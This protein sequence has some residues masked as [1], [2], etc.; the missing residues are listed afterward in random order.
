M[1]RDHRRAAVVAVL[2]RPAG[3]DG[4]GLD[5]LSHQVTGLEVRADLAGDL[6]PRLL[7]HH[8]SGELIYSLRSTAEGGRFG[9]TPTERCSRLVAAARY[10]DLIDLEIRDLTPEAL[11]RIPARQRRISWHGGPLDLPALRARFTELARTPARLYVLA[12]RTT[13]CGQ[14]LIPLQLLRSLGRA[15]V[16]AFGT[17]PSGT[18]SRVLAAWLGAPVVFGRLHGPIEAGV[19]TIRQLLEDYPVPALPLLRHLYGIVGGSLHR[20]M[21]PRLHNNAYRQ[22][23][24]P[25]LFL[26]F[27]VEALAAGWA[28]LASGLDEIGLPLLGLTVMGPHKEAALALADAV[29]PTA[30]AAGSA[31]VLLRRGS[32]WLAETTD[33]DAVAA[34]L[35]RADVRLA[36][37]KV[38]VVGC[39]GA[40][41]AAAVGLMRAGAETVL[42]NRGRDRGR[43]AAALLGLPFVPLAAFRPDGYSVVVH[44]TPL[45]DELPFPA[46]RLPAGAVVVDLVYRPGP[47]ALTAIARDLGLVTID[48]WEVLETEVTRQFGL[49]TGRL[50]PH[51]DAPALKSAG[52]VGELR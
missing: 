35:A 2:A 12:P 14:A 17:G 7:R 33:T 30:R 5:H 49:M 19:P 43:A 22:L 27:H 6:D 40:G 25:A 52:S 34:V 26:P 13:S 51:T 32:R 31:N 38:A 15:D 8:F 10:Y 3:A 4:L 20:S 47:T 1:P 46:D 16:T 48:G 39:G 24:L 28:R 18:W 42:V 29:T 23:G 41:R 45:C 21:S 11:A 9:G 44:A 37:R 50:L 36:G